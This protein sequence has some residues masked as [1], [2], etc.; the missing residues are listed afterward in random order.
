MSL[1]RRHKKSELHPMHHSAHGFDQY[2]S[3][4]DYALPGIPNFIFDTDTFSFVSLM[5]RLV[6][7]NDTNLNDR[8]KQI[9]KALNERGGALRHEL[10]DKAGL[11]LNFSKITFIRDLNYL[12]ANNLVKRTGRG[13]NTRYDLAENNPIL[14]FVDLDD[15]FRTDWEERKITP[16]FNSEVLG[17]LEKLYN[18]TEIFLWE[19]S[20][21]RFKKARLELDPSIYKRE[22]ERFVIEF[23][24]K[25]SQIE[26]NTYTLLEAETLIKQNIQAKGHSEDEA[27]MILN[28]KIAFDVILEKKDSFKVVDFSDIIQLHQIL[29]KNLVTSGIRSQKVKISGTKYE[30]MSDRQEIE[31]ALRSLI[32]LIN[33]LKYPPEKALVAAIMIAYIQPFADGNKRTSRMLSNAILLAYDY[34][35]LSYRGVDVNEYRSA[36]IVFYEINNLY[37]FKRLF[38]QQLQFAI[39]N[40]F[41]L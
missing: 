11:K 20:Q 37:N 39:E 5:I 27:K 28:H 35:P 40:Y 10:V 4:Q 23:S 8:Q 30:P 13:K 16:S 26:G 15:Y 3:V 36:M 29:T 24:W 2:H 34:F 22:L 31:I 25:S 14:S 19:K 12:I 6:E 1:K 21:E 38:V 32:K 41:Q 9:L 33:N 17:M 7:M 18:E